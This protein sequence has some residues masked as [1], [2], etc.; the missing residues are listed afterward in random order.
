V[1]LSRIEELALARGAGH[2]RDDIA[3]LAARLDP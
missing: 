2:L 3:I 1:L